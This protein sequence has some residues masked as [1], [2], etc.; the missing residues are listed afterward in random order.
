MDE[1]GGKGTIN[2]IR[3]TGNCLFKRRLFAQML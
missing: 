2:I 3:D 1:E